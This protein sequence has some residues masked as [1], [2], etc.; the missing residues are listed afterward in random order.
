[1]K[2]TILKCYEKCFN[3]IGTHHEIPSAK[4]QSNYSI[5]EIRRSL[6][7]KCIENCLKTD[8]EIMH[9]KKLVKKK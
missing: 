5:K 9:E 3:V 6:R 2:K 7:N 8:P 1:M 4:K